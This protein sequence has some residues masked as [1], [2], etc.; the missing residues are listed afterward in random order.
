MSPS[1]SMLGCAVM[2]RQFSV[3]QTQSL[4]FQQAYSIHSN[5]TCLTVVSLYEAD[6]AKQQSVISYLM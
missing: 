3:K 4:E 2:A 1:A 5:I 6:V